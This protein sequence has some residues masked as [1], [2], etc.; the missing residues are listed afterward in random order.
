MWTMPHYY[1]DH[2][3]NAARIPDED[4]VDLPDIEAAKAEAA[5]ALAEL[6]HQA[7]PG[8]GH[9]FSIE[10]RDQREPVLHCRLS[11]EISCLSK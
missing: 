9:R 3:E 10:V 5:K 7:P 6:V 1:F 8:D 11:L 2:I 4:G